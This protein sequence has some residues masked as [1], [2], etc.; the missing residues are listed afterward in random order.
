MK[1]LR[2][3][4]AKASTHQSFTQACLA[5]CR[6]LAAQFQLVKESVLAEF[7]GSLG[8]HE[9]LLRLAVNEAEA[10]AWQTAYPH[11]LFPAL[12]AE[13]AQA[14]T[15]WNNHQREV[16]KNAWSMALIA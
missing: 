7:R 2:Q 1:A 4:D 5:S 15:R 11:L 9:E 16:K 12:A 14:V 10:L 3:T 8:A 13:K 6:K